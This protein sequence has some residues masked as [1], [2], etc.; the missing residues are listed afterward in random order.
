MI[1]PRYLM[2]RK[3]AQINFILMIRRGGLRHKKTTL[4]AIA[5][6]NQLQLLDCDW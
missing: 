1:Y 6:H 3:E 2:G 4:A 5:A